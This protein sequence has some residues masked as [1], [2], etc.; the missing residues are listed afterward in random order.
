MIKIHDEE[1]F[2]YFTGLY[3]GKGRKVETV[4]LS[5][6]QVSKCLF[7][8][9]RGII[10][11]NI[12][13]YI[14]TMIDKNRIG[15][16]K[17]YRADGI[18]TGRGG[19]FVGYEHCIFDTRGT[20]ICIIWDTYGVQI[21]SIK[22]LI[23]NKN[24][25][26]DNHKHILAGYIDSKFKCITERGKKLIRSSFVDAQAAQDFL[27]YMLEVTGENIS[28]MISTVQQK[29]KRLS[30]WKKDASNLV[31]IFGRMKINDFNLDLLGLD[32]TKVIQSKIHQFP[33]R[34]L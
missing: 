12:I 24:I 34:L 26:I 1:T 25:S 28:C 10:P 29:Y 9:L 19:S 7:L 16:R 2:W 14:E 20:E 18:I 17:V 13:R 23:G 32:K 27:E 15:G 33:R 31:G 3:I 21:D 22:S 4:V 8:E 5:D 6:S 11:V 30:I